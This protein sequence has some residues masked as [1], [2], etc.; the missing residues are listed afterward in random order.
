MKL[1]KIV[2]KLERLSGKL[3]I[4]EGEL[5]KKIN[6]SLWNIEVEGNLAGGSSTAQALFSAIEA[7][8]ETPNYFTEGPADPLF[9]PETLFPPVLPCSD[10][11][12]YC[13]NSGGSCDNP[14]PKSCGCK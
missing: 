4:L 2:S 8:K 9:E 11:D 6:L 1:K 7:L 10:E 12:S 3:L 14:S 13:I 5:K